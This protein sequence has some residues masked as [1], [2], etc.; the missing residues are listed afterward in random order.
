MKLQTSAT[1]IKDQPELTTSMSRSSVVCVMRCFE[2]SKSIG[3]DGVG[4][5]RLKRRDQRSKIREYK[6]YKHQYMFRP[7]DSDRQSPNAHSLWSYC[8]APSHLVGNK[9]WPKNSDWRN[10]FN[11]NWKTQITTISTSESSKRSAIYLEFS[12]LIIQINLGLSGVH[13]YQTLKLKLATSSPH[14]TNCFLQVHHD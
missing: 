8:G 12:T 9:R 7:F 10:H 3:P 14:Y 2:K 5:V 4:R 6:L 11:S 1:K 13:A